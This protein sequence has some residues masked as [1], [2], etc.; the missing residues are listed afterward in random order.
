MSKAASAEREN[1]LQIVSKLVETSS[2]DTLY[3]DLYFQRARELMATTLSET[4]YMSIKQNAASLDLLERQ[5]RTAV[6][7]GDWQRTG[8]L[9]ERVRGI[10][11]T[12]AASSQSMGMAEAVYDRLADVPIDPFS[13]GLHVFL[14]ASTETLR[15][16]RNRAMTLLSQLE[17]MDSPQRAFYA[18]RL[19][20]FQSLKTGVAAKPEK[21]KEAATDLQQAA[22]SALD[23]GDLSQLDR[24]VRQLMQ[25]PET[26]EEKKDAASVKLT[27][28][29]ALGDDLL[30]SFSEE[31]LGLAQRLGLAP[32]RTHSRRHFAH[33]IPYGWQ[34]SFLKTE[35]KK[36]ARDQ[37]THLLL[38]PSDTGDR[39]RDAIELYLLNPFIN[40]GGTRYQVCLV[41][42]DLLIED[43][44]EPEPK[45]AMPRTELLAALGL[46]SRW[47][48]TRIDLETALLQHGPRILKEKLGLDPEAFKL[49][50]IP[51]DIYTALGPARGWG[52]KEMWTHFDGYWVLEGGKRQALAGGD[53]RFGGTHDVISFSPIYTTDKMLTRLAVV[54]RKRMM[55]WHQ[56]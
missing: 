26:K 37:L 45:A 12:S 21:E 55:T 22:L 33:L 38:N 20:D 27:E 36:W 5:L 30:F 1:A 17:R 18:R 44:D 6:E 54:Q 8:E 51:P 7:R 13:P 2:F 4:A 9:T 16:W 35:S 40:S 39:S 43:F 29:T 10:R 11:E 3:R 28:A 32:A 48:L 56:G 49:V 24:V 15:E 52:Q 42:E 34:P 47:G 46:E 19:S 50:A 53:K 41:E 23:S 31:T 14:N 25:K